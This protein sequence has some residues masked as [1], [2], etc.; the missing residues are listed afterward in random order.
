MCAVLRVREGVSVTV[1][2]IRKH[3]DGHIARFKIPR[4]LKVIDEFPK[5]A[6]GKIQKYRLKDMIEAGKL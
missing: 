4:V 1:D 6:S 2:D 3:C 5:T